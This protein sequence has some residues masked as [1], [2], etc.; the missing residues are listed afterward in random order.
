MQANRSTVNWYQTVYRGVFSRFANQIRRTIMK[1]IRK[2]LLVTLAA[3][4]CAL[5]LTGCGEK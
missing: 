1:K 3:A 2:L 4:L 5:L